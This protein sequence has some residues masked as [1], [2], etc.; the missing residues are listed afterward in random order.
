M[1]LPFLDFDVFF[2]DKEMTQIS[3]C[4]VLYQLRIISVELC[5]DISNQIM[6]TK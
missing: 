5:E 1:F 2:S 4:L 3:F 6:D